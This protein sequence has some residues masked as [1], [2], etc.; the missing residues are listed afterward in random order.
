MS[1]HCC[2][3]PGNSRRG[4]QE[5]PLDTCLRTHLPLGSAPHQNPRWLCTGA[6]DD[7]LGF[8]AKPENLPSTKNSS[9]KRQMLAEG[10]RGREAQ[11]AACI[12]L[13]LPARGQESLRQLAPDRRPG[14]V[15]WTTNAQAGVLG[16][17]GWSGA[18]G[19]GMLDLGVLGPFF[20]PPS[21]GLGLRGPH[22]HSLLNTWDLLGNSTHSSCIHRICTWSV[23][24]NAHCRDIYLSC[25]A[26]PTP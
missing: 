16:C 17:L 11:A 26:A 20:F 13:G 5:V 24:A 25:S 3:H 12:A 10:E 6:G 19:R 18:G 15:E 4:W 7:S 9:I 1:H 22:S 2:S 21:S 14:D 8:M 23:A